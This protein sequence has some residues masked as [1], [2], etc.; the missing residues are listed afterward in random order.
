MFTLTQKMTMGVGV[1]S[2]VASSMVQADAI[3]NKHNFEFKTRFIHFDREF[4][5]SAQNRDQSAIGYILN[6]QSPQFSHLVGVNLSGYYLAELD[7]SGS[8]NE[9]ILTRESD[10]DL[11][12]FSQIGE[13][14]INVTPLKNLSIKV[15]RQQH[16][17]L[18]FISN[19]SRAVPNT[20]RGININYQATNH[21]QFYGAVYDEFSRRAR[22]TFEE[23]STDQSEEGSIDY[24]SVLGLKYATNQLSVELENF[25]AD[26]YLTKF[27]LRASY[28]IPFEHSKLKIIGGIFTSADDGDLFVTG[29][30]NGD[31]DDEDAIGSVVGE[32]S[33]SNDGLGGFVDFVWS[34]G[35]SEWSL[36]Y[37][38]IEEIW[39]EDNFAGY[40][41]PNPFPTDA[42][43]GPD[44]TNS[45]ENVVR[46]KYKYDWHNTIPGLTTTFS[47]AY[48]WDA[49]NSEDS[50][51]GQADENWN[52]IEVR[53]KVPQIK[54]L[55]VRGIWHQYTSD[56]FGQVDGV[57]PDQEDFRLY[58]D[59]TYR[60]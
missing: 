35:P 39:L 14:Y 36:A 30:E 51:L 27:G 34:K 3:N 40:H 37:T 49:E 16:H 48:G 7:H 15:G 32:T 18:L 43:V 9:D 20:Y 25:T 24:V 11:S 47:A 54:N 53:Y 31:L 29:A 42:R 28:L 55:Q 19:G 60:F 6:Y 45:G 12:G 59:Y 21:L 1:L 4:D 10:G 58:V 23:F 52:E 50:S 33:S 2:L 56:E 26:E 38:K 22:G 41:G 17:S 8:N 46:L 44:L 57:K 13:A 5:N